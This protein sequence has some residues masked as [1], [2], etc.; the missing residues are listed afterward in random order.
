MKN[1]R[2]AIVIVLGILACLAAPAE[3]RPALR[4]LQQSGA[5]SV[6]S[7]QGQVT[8]DG[9]AYSG[10]GYFKFAVVNA[11]GDTT[12][13]SNDG[14][15]TGGGEP[16]NTVQLAVSG[17]LF[18]VLLGD[19]SLASMTAL[20][21]SAFDGTDRY[22]RVWFSHDG[23]SFDQL[24]PDRRIAAVPYAL[25][26]EEAK[27]AATA[28]DAG[29]LGGLGS[30][31]FWQLG[32]NGGTMPGSEYLGTSDAVSLTLAT[33]GTAA[34]TV[35]TAGNVGVGEASPAEKLT[36]AAGNFLQTPGAPAHAGA[37]T[38]TATTALNYAW[39]IYVAGKYAYV[40]SDADDGVEIL[41]ISDPANPTHVG[42]ITDDG[43]T[44][45]NVAAGIYVAGH[46]AYVAAYGDDGV[47]VL[48]ISD[49]ANP[50]HVGAIT[51]DGTTELDGA[52]GIYVV[53]HYAYVAACADDG[54]EV[55]DISDPA[56][57]THVGAITD[58]GTTAL[59]GATDIYVAGKYAY[60]AAFADDG[61]EV[62]DI[63]DPANPTHV[64]VIF[65]DATTALDGAYS[66]YVAGHYAYVATGS[67]VAASS[68][69]GVEVLDISDPS[70]PTHVGAIFDDATTALDGAL[71]IYVVGKYAYVAACYD[72][73]VEVL[74]I[75][76]LTAPVASIGA[77]EAGS[78]QVTANAQVGHDLIVH[79]GLNVGPGGAL[80]GGDVGV[81][82]DLQVTGS[83]I[84]FPTIS[85]AAPPAA[86]CD[87]AREAGRVV[88]RTDGTTNL[89]VCTGG[90]GW[91][92]K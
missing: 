33:N 24:S 47:E 39:G 40:A 57:P 7:Y 43:T 71:D 86:D 88:V 83:Y 30:S 17:G 34:V 60:V 36:L 19:T 49:P 8:L 75:T 20:G 81:E 92:G 51:D 32:G 77:V 44:E 28:G 14:T 38:D 46:Y 16:T 45:L 72:D 79:G 35:D 41:D 26:A 74:D 18:N 85:G 31:A 52:C 9:S 90:G 3:A 76:G 25:Q 37:I 2:I 11:A 50:T 27:N 87:E 15:S 67:D 55:L 59:D 91:V 65:D 69:D 78:L 58:D 68:E 48:D 42:A 84:Q 64:G 82:G 63:S 13:W 89:Y 1:K 61:V 12:Y 54:V 29:T 66:I 80:V 62:L 21:A 6:V 4:P 73:G 56:N 5:P 22:L 70:N 23:I 10:T 53:G